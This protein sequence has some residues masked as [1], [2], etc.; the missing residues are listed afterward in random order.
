MLAKMIAPLLCAAALA[1]A[2]AAVIEPS[3]FPLE[4]PIVFASVPLARTASSAGAHIARLDPPDATHPSG[5]ITNLT[6]EFAAASRPDVSFDGRRI[7]FIGQRTRDD[8][9]AVWEMEADGGNPREMIAGTAACSA[10]IYLSTIY[11]LDA[12][13]PVYQLAVCAGPG[14]VVA[15]GAPGTVAFTPVPALFTCRMDG[16]RLERITFA[17]DGVSEPY[18]LSDGRLLYTGRTAQ[19]GDALFSVH[20]DGTDLSL[21]AEPGIAGARCRCLCETP[22]GWVTY[23]ENGALA[24]VR[25]ARSLHTRRLVSATDDGQYHSATSLP[26]GRLLVSFCGR[27]DPGYGLYVLDPQTGTRVACLYTSPEWHAVDGQL[28]RARAVPAGRSSVVTKDAATGF[29]YALNCYES[30]TGA[31]KKIRPGEIRRLQVFRGTPTRGTAE[32]PQAEL[33]AEV[34]VEAD[35]S[36]FLEVPACVP[37]CWQTL[38]ADGTI[39]QSMK[40]WI[41]VMPREGRGCVGCHEDR[42][43]AP[44]NRFTLALRAGPRPVGVTSSAAQTQPANATQPQEHLVETRTHPG[45][46]RSDEPELPMYVGQAV[47]GECHAPGSTG[48]ECSIPPVPAHE[49]AWVALADEKSTEIAALSG[50]FVPPASSVICLGCHAAA[51]E[52]GPRWTEKTFDATDGVQCETCHG[53]ASLHVAHHRQVAG[54]APSPNRAVLRHVDRLVCSTCHRELPSHVMVLDQGHRRSPLDAR[55]KT[56]VKIAVAA[57]GTRLYV[58]C[59]HSNSLLVIDPATGTVLREIPVG[60]RPKDVAVSPDGR[61]LYVTNYLSD[62]VTVIDATTGQATVEVPVGSEPH[63]AILDA[64]GRQLFVLNTG[65]NSISVLDTAT[66]AELRRLTAGTGPWSVAAMPDGQSLYVTSVRPEPGAFCEPHRSEIT[67]VDAESGVARARVAV[68]DANMLKGIA[69][70]PAGPYRGA[71]LFVLMRTKNL[72]PTTR[73]AQGWVITNGLGVLWPDGRVDQVLLDQPAECFPDPEDVAVDPGGRWA[74]VTSGASDQVAVVDLEQ[75]AR[76]PHEMDLPDRLGLADRFVLKRVK[77]GY[78]PRGVVFAPDG[79]HAYVANALDDTLSVIETDD[80]AV[81]ATIDLGGPHEVTELR[82]GARLFHSAAGT[83]A[84]QFSC[85]SCHPDG[86][87][88]GLAMDIEADGIG[89]KPVDNRTLRGI[90]DT[91]PFKWEGRNPTLQRQCGPR[92]AVFF[93]RV[94]P[95]APADLDALVR[96]MCVLERP[97]NRYRPADG[98]TPAQYRGKLVF[99]RTCDNAGHRMRAG[100]Q[101]LTCHNGPYKTAQVNISART[102]MWFDERMDVPL[103]DA[104]LPDDRDF[105]DLGIFIFAETGMWS[106]PLDVPQLTNIYDSPP[107]LHNGAANTL[108]EIWTRFNYTESHGLTRDLTRQQLNDLM[109]YLRAL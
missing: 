41:W 74:L 99:E 65:E 33:L 49:H 107:Y 66:Q 37:L 25:R 90:L 101:C 84:A 12:D 56:P 86:H 47:C 91:G 16:R 7:L 103:R 2:W 109:A 104:G 46:P 72:V 52:E 51:A 78:N 105:G 57:D 15:T 85:Q 62:S 71:A 93:T 14:Q 97:R 63:G 69:C 100:Q 58:V 88:N 89:L 18:L 83:F 38:G 28:L 96:Y 80:F 22:D 20:T 11:T 4:D 70:V 64:T 79:R 95:Y 27:T 77:V 29:V 75:F 24:A 55:Y 61:T 23:L 54:N 59:E 68:P 50:I 92:F 94:A 45:A 44:P 108:E 87:L 106:A 3:A 1:P 19:G 32:P 8:L 98:L 6:L 76:L 21:F 73:I 17:P 82:R 5:R 36:F 34:P 9:P 102:G 39:L 67:V 81:S 43:L 48:S 35:G 31:G 40:N 30:D 10:A 53:P 13:E 60:M 26:D 42:E